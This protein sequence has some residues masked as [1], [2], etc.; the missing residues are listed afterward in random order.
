MAIT[1][2]S[3]TAAAA[4]GA[5]AN[6]P[7]ALGVGSGVDTAALVKSL[8]DAQ[9]AGKTARLTNQ[10]E[11]LTSQ[12][13]ALAEVKSGI[14]GF[15]GALTTLV[16][17]GAL[18]TQ[19]TSSSNAVRVTT[20][21][22]GRVTGIN[23]R[24]EV[25]RLASGQVAAMREGVAA[26]T[27]LGSGTLQLS[28]GS[29]DSDGVFAGDGRAIPPITISDADGASLSGI[30]ARITAAN[31]GV[32]AS[33]VSD[34]KGERIVLKGPTGAAQAF[35]LTAAGD[36]RLS[37]LDIGFPQGAVGAQVATQAGNA[38]LTVDGIALSRDSNSVSGAIP[39]VR[40]DLQSVTGGVAA[41][42]G[43]SA[44][45]D[46]LSQA[47]TNVVATFNE[48]LASVKTATD[49]ING[50][51]RADPA[52]TALQRALSRFTL[53]P[54]TNATD[55]SPR[56]LAE[57]GVATNRD[58]TLRVDTAV[59]TKALASYPATIEAMFAAGTA[60]SGDGLSVA[61]NAISAT[62]TGAA[63]L[64]ASETR[65]TKAKA[66]LGNEQLRLTEQSTNVSTRM[67][68]QFAASEA[69]VAAYKAQQTFM[70]NQIKMWSKD[71]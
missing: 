33:V 59:L 19:P 42:I 28:F 53:T 7:K 68:Q 3:T 21:P 44:P 6:I 39:G 30:A 37:R 38:E 51:L 60:A 25:S 55:G 65:Y 35:T 12:I 17:S 27:G 2:G 61:L 4:S 9:F 58:G 32:T 57:I 29:V 31:A 69:R 48:V 47:V 41:S 63:G 40:L 14:G 43:S 56:T 70:E 5:A 50:A 18:A 71:G 8:V 15:A 34:A 45:T 26:G 13:S 52:A 46:A 67:T 23:A 54:L 10:S 20:L 66:A 11:T 62:A 36:P 1:T 22:G 24:V 64:G 49:P 16:K